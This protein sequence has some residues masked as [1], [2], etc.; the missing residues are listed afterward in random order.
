MEG[1]ALDGHTFHNLILKYSYGET[2]L[3]N[4]RKEFQTRQHPE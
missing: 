1:V 2:P 3:R 4:T